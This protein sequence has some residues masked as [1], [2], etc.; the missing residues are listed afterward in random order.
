[1]M[2]PK[3]KRIKDRKMISKM[4]GHT[5][6]RCGAYADI[7]P[8]H[9]FTVGSGGGDIR[10]NLVQLCTDCHIGVHN[11]AIERAELLDI[12]ATREHMTVDEAYS[13]NRRAMGWDV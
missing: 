10:V 9:V 6:E 3:H 7:E 2:I 1:M 5:C 8:H 13:M 11:G 4:R 12:I